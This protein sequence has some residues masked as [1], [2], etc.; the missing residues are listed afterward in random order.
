MANVTPQP[1]DW[2]TAARELAYRL[3]KEEE[4][5]DWETIRELL[6]LALPR[7]VAAV[8]VDEWEREFGPIHEEA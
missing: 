1:E 5:Y 8:I 4:G 3:V 7:N 6:E 2:K